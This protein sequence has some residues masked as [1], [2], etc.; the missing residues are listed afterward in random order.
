MIILRCIQKRVIVIIIFLLILF[1]FQLKAQTPPIDLTTLSIEDLLN[2]HINRQSDSITFKDWTNRWSLGYH[3]VR[4]KFDDY[5]DGTDHVS[6]TK[7]LQRFAIVPEEIVQE[8]H[9]SN[10]TF[11]ASKKLN[12]SILVPYICQNTDHISQIP[13]FE[14][15]N[16]RTSGI[17]DITLSASYLFILKNNHH[18]MTN[19][20]VSLP[21]GSIDEKGDTPSP[22]TRNQLP[23][24]MQL[25]SGTFDPIIG[26]RYKGHSGSASWGASLQ[27]KIHLGR[28]KREY[29]LGDN[30][31]L[32]AWVRSKLLFEWLEPSVKLVAQISSTIDGHDSDL[33]A[34]GEV[35]VATPRYFGG[36][37]VLVLSGLRFNIQ[38]GI[39]QGSSIDVEGGL[40]VYQSTNGP[41]PGE[42][43]RLSIGFNLDF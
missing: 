7:L 39:L 5:L 35:P 28:N 2:L 18:F 43:W 17:G 16:I 15:F 22:G 36:E 13:G 23:Y 14:R 19:L 24:T 21:S 38:N 32:T 25:G 9:M 30:L 26:L 11:Q 31:L 20:G 40:P 8:M 3:Y 10:I 1:P 27:S 33:P 34:P 29:S 6:N 42:E 37:K 41:F 4:V 12:L